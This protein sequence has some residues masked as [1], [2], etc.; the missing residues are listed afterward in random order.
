[1]PGREDLGT[2]EAGE[3][4]TPAWHGQGLG[5]HLSKMRK[6]A[7]SFRVAPGSW[8]GLCLSFPETIFS[9]LWP[10]T[11]ACSTLQKVSLGCH[12]DTP[13]E[14]SSLMRLGLWGSCGKGGVVIGTQDV[15]KWVGMGNW[16]SGG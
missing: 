15:F 8:Q 13:V 14:P 4:D 3:G 12:S 1:M 11:L 6:M 7:W 9:L 16:Q 10:R 5:L 2:E